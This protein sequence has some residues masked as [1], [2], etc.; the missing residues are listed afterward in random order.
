MMD[1]VNI[2][3][4]SKNMAAVHGKNTSPELRVRRMLH[5]MG[6]RF[7]LNKK[8]L[9]GKPDIVLPKYQLCIFVNGCFWHQHSSCKRATVPETR[10]EFWEKKFCETKER[11]KKSFIALQKLGWRVQTIWECETKNPDKLAVIIANYFQFESDLI[12]SNPR[13][14]QKLVGQAEQQNN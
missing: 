12:S 11:D 5:S 1:K 4:R 3:Q 6:F 2:E 9:P 10:K 8:D 13:M 7:R 14:I